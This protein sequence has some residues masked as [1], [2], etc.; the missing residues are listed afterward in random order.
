MRY[1]EALDVALRAKA[2]AVEQLTGAELAVQQGEMQ[3]RKA[4]KVVSDHFWL[5]QNA[6]KRE[7]EL[8]L[9]GADIAEKYWRSLP[10]LEN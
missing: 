8:R 4:M 7:N 5:H 6:L 1:M 3:C 9:L 10:E 2:F